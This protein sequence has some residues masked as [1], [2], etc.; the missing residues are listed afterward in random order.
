MVPAGKSG[1]DDERANVGDVRRRRDGLGLLEAGSLVRVRIDERDLDLV[2]RGGDEEE[3]LS[4]RD[5]ARDD[6]ARER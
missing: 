5:L 4:L 1:M 2:L 6:R 3:L